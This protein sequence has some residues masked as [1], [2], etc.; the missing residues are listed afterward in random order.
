MSLG[1]RKGDKVYVLTGKDKGKTGKV[2]RVLT[3]KNRAIVEGINLV[4]KHVR[5]R[6]ESEPGGIKDIPASIHISN[7]NLFCAHC[8][9]GVRWGI[10]ILEDK[11]KIRIC[12]KCG[13][14][15]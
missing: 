12:K 7:L 10:K 8:N 2:L 13:N 9:R 3:S 5:R 4:K 1:I 11:S 15:L 6:S 14:S